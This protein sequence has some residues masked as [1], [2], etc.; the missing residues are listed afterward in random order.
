[1]VQPKEAIIDTLKQIPEDS[2]L[3]VSVDASNSFSTLLVLVEYLK[4]V[5]KLR[6]VYVSSSKSV[7]SL[8]EQFQAR[9]VDVKGLYF[10]DTIAILSGSR[11]NIPGV[12][13]VESP[14]MLE[15]I[16]LKIKW[17]F[18]HLKD[19]D[20]FLLVDSVNSLSVYNEPKLLSEFLHILTNHMGAQDVMTV[21]FTVESQTPP[22][23]RQ[24]LELNCDDF[25]EVTEQGV[26]LNG[27]LKTMLK[28]EL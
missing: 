26:T 5:R 6:G 20:R 18:K 16:L 1:M 7:E 10:V 11:V 13:M 2:L 17:F 4:N 28:E 27:E 19:A 21:L 3:T 8:R 24:V 15:T 9:E 25:M 23:V 14:A 22:E 12:Q